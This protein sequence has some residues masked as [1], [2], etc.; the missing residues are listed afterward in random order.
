MNAKALV[1]DGAAGGRRVAEGT[2]AG[3]LAWARALARAGRLISAIKHLEAVNPGLPRDTAR[4]IVDSF[5]Y[6]RESRWP[7]MERN[8]E[9]RGQAVQSL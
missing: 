8:P 1:R 3:G 5:G 7:E 9:E 6:G 2:K 4:A